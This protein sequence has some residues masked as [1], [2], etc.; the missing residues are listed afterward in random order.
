[1]KTN[2]EKN[3]VT[4]TEIQNLSLSETKHT[5]Q[6]CEQTNSISLSQFAMILL[7]VPDNCLIFIK[8]SFES[9]S[10]NCVWKGKISK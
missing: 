2:T 10:T 9:S 3:L 1:M 7:F 5:F 6:L 4:Y 8:F